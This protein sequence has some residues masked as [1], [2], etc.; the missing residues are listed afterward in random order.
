ME[1][2]RVE[3][4][5]W[6]RA[7]K[8]WGKVFPIIAIARN[9]EEK[10]LDGYSYAEARKAFPECKFALVKACRREEEEESIILGRGR[11]LLPYSPRKQGNEVFFV[12]EEKD[13]SEGFIKT[14]GYCLL[15]PQMLEVFAKLPMEKVDNR[16]VTITEFEDYFSVCFYDGTKLYHRRKKMGKPEFQKWK[17][18]IIR[19]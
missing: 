6:A 3:F 18:G 8:I 1:E 12:V 19:K 11:E 2:R 9:G 10:S 14:S 13:E 4:L 15:T 7:E 16:S 17:S 5:P